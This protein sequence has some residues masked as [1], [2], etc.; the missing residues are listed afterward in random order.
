MSSL[1]R[2]RGGSGGFS[3]FLTRPL[4]SSIAWYIVQSI[5]ARIR[6]GDDLEEQVVALGLV[7]VAV[8]TRLGHERPN[9]YPTL[10][11]FKVEGVNEVSVGVFP[12]T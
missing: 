12:K 2:A 10:A 9:Q 1:A 6:K 11:K 3:S 4:S 5:P 7:K 8:L